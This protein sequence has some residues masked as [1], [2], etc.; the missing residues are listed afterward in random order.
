M[1]D[2]H[3]RPKRDEALCP[4]LIHNR[5]EKGTLEECNLLRDHEYGHEWQPYKEQEVK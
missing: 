3:D 4:Y 5:L 2:P 1:F